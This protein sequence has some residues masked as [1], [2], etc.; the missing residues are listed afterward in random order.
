MN[1]LD[2][3]I[4]NVIEGFE[5]KNI[6]CLTLVDLS[7]AFDSISHKILIDKIG[8]GDTAIW[9]LSSY[10][11]NR[12]QYVKLEHNV[13]IVRNIL[14]GV[15]Q[16]SL[17]G[18][19]LFVIYINDLPCFTDLKSVL[20]ADMTKFIC[21]GNNPFTLQTMNDSN[22]MKASEWSHIITYR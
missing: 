14:T 16:G 9:L 2:S 15:P 17:L 21:S 3:V 10:P 7:R 13:S 19:L 12:S 1:A 4:T 6:T 11:Y 5:N 20:Y 18:F 8:I 22:L